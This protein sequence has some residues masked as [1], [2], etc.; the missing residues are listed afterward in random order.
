MQPRKENDTNDI[1]NEGKKVG[2]KEMILG[3]FSNIQF[4]IHLL[5]TIPLLFT[6]RFMINEKALDINITNT[7]IT[8]SFAQH[9]LV[10]II[11]LAVVIMVNLFIYNKYRFEYGEDEI[12]IDNIKIHFTLKTI[13]PV[14]IIMQA[15]F[16][17]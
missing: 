14:I 15:I 9:L 4:L 1:I 12:D 6:L 17:Y 11:G 8:Q 2:R 13:T 7:L 5:I 16:V 10:S 3:A